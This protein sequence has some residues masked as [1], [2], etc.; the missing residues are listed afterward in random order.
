MTLQDMIAA[1]QREAALRRRV[2]PRMIAQGRVL[3]DN[4]AHEIEA[5]DAI[6][7][8]LKAQLPPPPETQ[9]TLL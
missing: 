6:V 2:Y 8:N 9:P 5:M 7:A 4:A 3:P 1:A